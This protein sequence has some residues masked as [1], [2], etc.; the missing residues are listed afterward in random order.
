MR[1]VLTSILAVWVVAVLLPAAAFAQSNS[2]IAGTC[3]ECNTNGDCLAVND[4]GT[5]A[6]NTSMGL[7]Q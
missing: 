5:L 1:R 6:C 7:C 4:A 2:N 3:V